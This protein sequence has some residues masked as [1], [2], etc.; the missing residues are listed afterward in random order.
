MQE[1]GEAW[2]L[3]RLWWWR[4]PHE[5]RAAPGTQGECCLWLLLLRHCHGKGGSH[6]ERTKSELRCLQQPHLAHCATPQPQAS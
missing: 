1:A 6:E 2:Q 5:R 3:Q 4:R